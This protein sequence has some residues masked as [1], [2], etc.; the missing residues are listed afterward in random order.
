M[1]H[2]QEKPPPQDSQSLKKSLR[3][4]AEEHLASGRGQGQAQE[5][6]LSNQR[7]RHELS[8][9]QIELELQNEE[10]KRSQEELEQARTYLLG[11]FTQ[12]PL[13]CVT[14]DE[15]HRIREAN[16]AAQELFSFPGKLFAVDMDVFI[17]K[18]HLSVLRTT[19]GRALRS[20]ERQSCEVQY[21]PF[22]DQ[23]LRWMRLHCAPL[24]GGAAFD[25]VVLC[26]ME[27]ITASKHF[28]QNLVLAKS[29][30]ESEVQRRTHEMQQVVEQLQAEV[31]EHRR[32]EHA[33]R[34]SEDRF[35]RLV[36]QVP[37]IVYTSELGGEHAFRFVSRQAQ[38]TLGYSDEELT[39]LPGLWLAH[40]HPE[41]RPGLQ[42]ALARCH[43]DS[44]PLREEYRF[45]C[46]DG[47][48]IW[49]LDQATV[50]QP[51]AATKDVPGLELES[52]PFLQGLLFDITDK[53][54]LENELL[55]AK[56]RAESASLSKSEFL[57]NMSHEIRTPLNGVLGMLQLLGLSALDQDQEKF[58][59]L[60]M[61]SG[62]SL[63]RVINDIL[64]FSK[65]EAGKLEITTQPFY[66]RELAL[67]VV[68]VFQMDARAKG[69]ELYSSVSPR[70]PRTLIGDDARLRQILFNLVGNAVKFTEKGEVVLGL[71]ASPHAEAADAPAV[72]LEITV[73]DTGVGISAEYLNRIFEPFTQIDST[74]TRKHQGTGLGLGIVRRL[75]DL[76]Q[77][78]ISVRS[79][80]GQGTEFRLVLPLQA[81]ALDQGPD[82]VASGPATDHGALR[83][84]IAEDNAVN[85]TAAK[86]MLE[87]LGHQPTG[88]EDGRK[89]LET[90]AGDDFDCLLLDVQM[91]EVDGMQ[92]TRAI[93]NAPP[94]GVDPDIYIIAMTAH[95]MSGDRE[96][97]LQAGM[98][99][100][101]SK[102]VDLDT[103]EAV[104]DRAATAR[105]S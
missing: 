13:A 20:G 40:V 14:L 46:K 1:T 25:V 12:S 92:V 86:R 30:V 99:D 55:E 75:V 98:N 105:K 82:A 42:Q 96:R 47:R 69:L 24:P 56:S 22:K 89:A 97:F 84:L 45:F 39:G 54:R 28:E 103:L 65:I 58:V 59:K 100:Y 81:G 49:L 95:A 8:V 41:D 73:R 35:R 4:R 10:L 36:D 38:A 60:A 21:A 48:E 27:D 76:M 33:W 2:D 70:L 57:A 15:N 101:I 43:R 79:E 29:A 104:L 66:P 23:A 68:Q 26:S 71:D 88:V 77:G 67:S 72:M 50:I 7:V 85:M 62:H 64:D 44:E 83:V 19:I 94:P 53:K 17:S 34:I 91:P 63:L 11:L 37:A 61:D 74:F 90:L 31:E 3:T 18:K 32:A 5:Q 16:A 52:G 80:P 51:P 78:E 6:G 102:P 9:H 93:R 87:S